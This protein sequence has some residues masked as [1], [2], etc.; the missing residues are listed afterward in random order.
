MEEKEVKQK[1]KHPLWVIL[2]IRLFEIFLVLFFIAVLLICIDVGGF[3]YNIK[4]N[5]RVMI[6]GEVVKPENINCYRA[7]GDKESQKMKLKWN[8]DYYAVRVKAIPYDNYYIEYDVPT[9]AGVKHFKFSVFKAHNGLPVEWFDYD[10]KLCMEDNEWV[11]YVSL[12]DEYGTKTER[13]LLKDDP[14]AF[15]LIGP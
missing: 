4:G 7:S 6:N 15:I 12:G 8:E 14:E 11:A 1:K 3:S 9:E 10:L 13:I 2:T 5:I